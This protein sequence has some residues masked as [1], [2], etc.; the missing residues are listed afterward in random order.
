[1]ELGFLVTN[2]WETMVYKNMKLNHRIS[3]Y[4][5]YLK[6]F[7]NVDLDWELKLNLKVNEYVKA[8]IGTHVIYDDDI[9]FDEEKAADGT[10]TKAGIPRIQFK[11]I[12]GIGLA[13]DF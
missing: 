3:L 11:Q 1:M 7:G 9:L 10:I 2:K 13:Y 8:S 12:L 6:S 4:T 5:D